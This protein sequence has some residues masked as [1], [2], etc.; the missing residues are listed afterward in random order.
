MSAVKNQNFGLRHNVLRS[1]G[2]QSIILHTSRDEMLDFIDE[3]YPL[4]LV[5][6]VNKPIISYQLEYLE[7]YG[8]TNIMITVEKKYYKKMENYLKNFYNPVNDQVN[9]ELVVFQE[10]QEPMQVFRH[11]SQRITTSLIVMEGNC[12]VDVPLDAIL[13]SHV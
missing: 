4:A 2:Y 3:S 10:E 12:L 7:N 8:V 13:D 5:C 1:T 6:V 9:I 11:L